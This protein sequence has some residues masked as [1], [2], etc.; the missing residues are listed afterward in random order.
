[1]SASAKL[2]P[3]MSQEDVLSAYEKLLQ[4]SNKML[5]AARSEEWQDLIDDEVEYVSE[6]D[7]LSRY[8]TEAVLDSDA[9]LRKRDL[10]EKLLKQDREVRQLLVKRRTELQEMLLASSRKQ[11]VEHAYRK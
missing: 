11:R 6:V 10:L 8:E 7:R 2:K 9:Q 5:L 3:V 1:M 4:H